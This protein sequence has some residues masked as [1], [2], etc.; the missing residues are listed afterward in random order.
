LL[1]AP[2][3]CHRL[4]KSKRW[5]LPRPLAAPTTAPFVQ[6]RRGLPSPRG[7]SVFEILSGTIK[8]TRKQPRV[9]DK[10]R[11]RSDRAWSSARR[12]SAT[13]DRRSERRAPPVGQ[14]ATMQSR[15]LV[16]N[17]PHA[18]NALFSAHYLRYAHAQTT[19]APALLPYRPPH[20]GTNLLCLICPREGAIAPV[21]RK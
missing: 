1:S 6:R 16:P 4:F 9:S 5:C 21:H 8:R 19:A 2:P 14:P 10:T 20:L 15:L 18:G 3:S 7:R 13:P 11:P 17:C 12:P